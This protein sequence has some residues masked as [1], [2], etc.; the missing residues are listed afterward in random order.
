MSE[1]SLQQHEREAEAARAKLAKDLATLTSPATTHA[2][3]AGVKAEIVS[4][5]DA[6]I[7]SAQSRLTKPARNRRLQD[8]HHDCEKNRLHN[9]PSP[10]G[11]GGP[12]SF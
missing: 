10:L 11:R 4:A 2:F 1:P 9:H 12:K 3:K 8:D 5:K 6:L 7:D